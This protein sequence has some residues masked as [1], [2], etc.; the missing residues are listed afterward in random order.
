MPASGRPFNVPPFEVLSSGRPVSGQSVKQVT[1]QTPSR[2]L[3]ATQAE[4]MGFHTHTIPDPRTQSQTHPRSYWREQH[5]S[6]VS[7]LSWTR[8]AA[9][10]CKTG[11]LCHFAPRRRQVTRNVGCWMSFF[12]FFPSRPAPPLPSIPPAVVTC[13]SCQAS[14]QRLRQYSGNSTPAGRNLVPCLLCLL[15]LTASPPPAARLPATFC[16]KESSSLSL[17]GSL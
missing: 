8:Q 2:L 17:P 12:F 7:A 15:L 10:H 9:L 16:G 14:T 4:G 11:S 1:H 13:R 3:V 6:F 5:Q